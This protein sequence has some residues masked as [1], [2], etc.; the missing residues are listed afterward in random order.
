MK[1]DTRYAN[2]SITN[3][4]IG[5]YE[6]DAI[7]FLNDNANFRPFSLGLTTLIQK[8]GYTSDVND[9][10]SKSTFL[11]NKLK[12]SGVTVNKETVVSWFD[13][14]HRPKLVANSRKLMYQI[15]FSI[16]ASLDDT[17]WFFNH[18]Y[19]DKCFN[20]HM[21]QEV[22]YYYGLSHGYDY[23]TTESLLKTVQEIIDSNSNS[24]TLD[25]DKYTIEIK[26]DILSLETDEE[27]IAFFKDNYSWFYSWNTSAK[28][29]LSKLIENIRGNEID[30]KILAKIKANKKKKEENTEIVSKQEIESCH[31]VIR[32]ALLSD[33]FYSPVYDEE[34]KE[35]VNTSKYANRNITSI[36]FMLDCIYGTG[37]RVSRDASLPDI[38]KANFLD[39]IT[40]STLNLNEEINTSINTSYDSIRKALILLK[41]YEFWCT[42]KL[43]RKK[44]TQYS[45]H[46][47]FNEFCTSTNNV[48]DNA[49]YNELYA[50]NPYDW[51]FLK[52]SYVSDE[53]LE[54]FRNIICFI[55]PE[56]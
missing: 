38:V 44:Y 3:D 24:S 40:I 9:I 11:Y 45:H 56:E 55:L 19:Y 12:Q 37:E 2:A 15:C 4:D 42:I 16:S 31:L 22:V 47:L 18:V 43:N 26:E 20:F 25:E 21:F 51:I 1:G 17:V 54:Y 46:E 10:S 28:K 27:L 6:E 41:F 53:P 52:A 13:G 36:D 34:K 49:G 14:S 7:E 29:Q 5:F 32:E 35:N 30:K 39:K 23:K 8:Y 50:G 48:L 33:D